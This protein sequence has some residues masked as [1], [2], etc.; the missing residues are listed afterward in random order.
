MS[1][2]FAVYL[3]PYMQSTCMYIVCTLAHTGR[4]VEAAEGAADPNADYTG[5]I[6]Q[7]SEIGQ[8]GMGT[9]PRPWVCYTQSA[10]SSTVQ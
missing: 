5:Q 4:I 7:F 1:S 3:A 8:S 9:T 6:R 2:G 10:S